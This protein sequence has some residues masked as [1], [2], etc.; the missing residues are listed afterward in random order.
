LAPNG[1]DIR[2]DII[3]NDVNEP[4]TGEICFLCKRPK[5]QVGQLLYDN[6]LGLMGWMCDDCIQKI[7]ACTGSYDIA[8]TPERAMIDEI[9]T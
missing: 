1:D 7:S 8:G 2:W 3:N 6:V 5:D 9:A 4:R